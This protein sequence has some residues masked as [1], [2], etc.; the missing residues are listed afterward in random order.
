MM[1]RQ[2]LEALAGRLRRSKIVIDSSALLTSNWVGQAL[3]M[4]T[5]ILLA[6]TLGK[7]SY[8]L[9]IIAIALVNTITQFLDIR[10]NE[11]TVRFMTAALAE[12]DK[13]RAVTFFYVAISADV[14]LMVAT[15]LA[16]VI[17]VPLLIP[18]YD[19]PETLRAMARIYM[20]TVPFTTLESTFS[21]LLVVFKRFRAYSAIF[22]LNQVVLLGGVVALVWQGP[23]IVMW[24]V[25]K[26][27]QDDDMSRL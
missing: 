24:A 22:I 12:G 7:D 17:A 8:G 16:L 5:S 2:R 25:R 10:T 9:I 3:A 13:R 15:M 19:Q 27:A 4:V 20:L 11:G 6:R 21:A 1:I 26:P 14:A 23:V 18:I